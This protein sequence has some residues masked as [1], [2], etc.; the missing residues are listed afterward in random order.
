[1]YIE[2]VNETVDFVRFTA[3]GFF[4]AL[5]G[6]SLGTVKLEIP[7]HLGNMTVSKKQQYDLKSNCEAYFTS[8][9]GKA[10]ELEMT[11]TDISQLF[12]DR[13]QTGL[14]ICTYV[15]NTNN[16]G[17]SL[18][19]GLPT[20]IIYLTD[21]IW[22]TSA[23]KNDTEFVCDGFNSSAVIMTSSTILGSGKCC[24]M[25]LKIDNVIGIVRAFVKTNGT[26]TLRQ[27]AFKEFY[28]RSYGTKKFSFIGRRSY[29]F[30]IIVVY[31]AN[32]STSLR[33]V[34][35]NCVAIERAIGTILPLWSY[36]TS[37]L[38]IYDEFC[39]CND[40][41]TQ[42]FNCQGPQKGLVL[43]NADQLTTIT[44]KAMTS[45]SSECHLS[46]IMTTTFKTYIG[47]SILSFNRTR[48]P[49]F[50]QNRDGD[51][52]T[53]Y[54]REY[55]IQIGHIGEDFRV[56][57]H[58]QRLQ[59]N[60]L[61]GLESAKLLNCSE[62]SESD[63]FNCSSTEY[64]CKTGVCIEKWKRCN[65]AKDC[66][67]GD[68]EENCEEKVGL[69]K[70][71]FDVASNKTC[72]F[73]Q[74]EK[75]QCGEFKISRASLYGKPG[76][77]HTNRNDKGDMLY[78]ERKLCRSSFS[79]EIK[80]KK[81]DYALSNMQ[82]DKSKC[83]ITIAS[84]GENSCWWNL[85]LCQD[86]CL[87]RL[88]R[89]NT[90]KE[91]RTD[92]VTLPVQTGSYYVKIKA[93]EMCDWMAVD[94]LFFSPS[95]FA[96]EI[97]D[98]DMTWWITI[99]VPVVCLIVLLEIAVVS[100]AVCQRTLSSERIYDW[101]LG[102]CIRRKHPEVKDFVRE[103]C[104]SPSSLARF[105]EML[106]E[107]NPN[108][109]WLSERALNDCVRN[110]PFMKVCLDS[111]LGEGS[112]G[113]V[114]KGK[115]L[116]YGDYK[117]DIPIAIKKLPAGS[118]NENISDFLFEALTLSK[119]DHINIVGCLG[120]TSDPKGELLLILELMEGGDLRKYLRDHRKN[121]DLSVQELLKISIDIA[122]GCQYLEENKFI[123][124]DIAA[125]NCLLSSLDTNKIAKIGDFGFAKDIYGTDYY[126]KSEMTM[127][128]VRWMPE[129]SFKNGK[130]SSKSDVWAYGVLLWEIF[131]FGQLPY[132]DLTNCEVMA[133]V[134]NGHRMGQP[135]HCPVQVYNVM[136]ECWNTEPDKRPCFKTVVTLLSSIY[137]H[138]F[139]QNTQ[140][141]SNG[142]FS[143]KVNGGKH[144]LNTYSLPEEAE[145]VVP[146]LE[147]DCNVSTTDDNVFEAN[148]PV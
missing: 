33:I 128:P 18:V 110:I 62:T 73:L 44:S 140:Q 120:I 143:M 49:V 8:A 144:R 131:A 76:P 34:W 84:K 52:Y 61:L 38:T 77:E 32:A 121:E 136:G 109:A 125:R 20:L 21:P 135:R 132:E 63:E 35:K 75:N 104:V 111:L 72:G 146:L 12:V 80:T 4:P 112:F 126:K 13:T 86:S 123:H 133:K 58:L 53:H 46:L 106:T 31:D 81:F 103:S 7:R 137:T 85:Y 147:G 108:Y 102:S 26:E 23:C 116:K 55:K 117:D 19:Y 107:S 2:P 101:L 66:F 64:M 36:N 83:T 15:I 129:E 30:K 82:G 28:T 142:I 93:K 68:D 100:W 65:L 88:F 22:S 89:G 1:M 148:A 60:S 97:R 54:R 70:C 27:V 14:S 39:D 130:F 17:D 5:R 71:D 74:Y 114:F 96:S 11:D 138:T 115:L 25:D 141:N 24:R 59:L 10:T 29:N 98:S 127:V 92:V 56:Q 57:I 43:R 6:K 51:L 95:C 113:Q 118:M 47:V 90:T 139:S 45:F 145:T 124:R 69:W 91:W 94:D 134:M 42:V 119:F 40:T 37:D 3:D 16:T 67:H 79:A 99:V 50:R 105:N 48:F 41:L 122:H 87:K 9:Y 78:F